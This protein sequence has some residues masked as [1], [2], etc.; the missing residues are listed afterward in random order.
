MY[1]FFFLCN[2]CAKI[3][4]IIIL[5]VSYNSHYLNK[6]VNFYITLLVRIDSL[7]F[8]KIFGLLNL[9]KIVTSLNFLYLSKVG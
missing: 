5:L 8:P 3:E 4:I 7:T 6:G 1:K 9:K 2:I